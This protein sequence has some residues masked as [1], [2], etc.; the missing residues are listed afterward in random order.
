[1]TDGGKVFLGIDPEEDAQGI[2]DFYDSNS[3]LALIPSFHCV[4]QSPCMPGGLRLGTNPACMKFDT[5][6]HVH[7]GEMGPH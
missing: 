5:E 4:P 1:M 2:N 3:L 6:P 7:P